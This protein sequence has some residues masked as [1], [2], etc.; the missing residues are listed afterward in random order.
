MPYIGIDLLKKMTSDEWYSR[1][2]ITGERP[3]QLHHAINFGSRSINEPFAIVPLS[4]KVHDMVTPHN[5]AYDKEMEEK[6]MLI[7]LNRAT[8]AEIRS[9]SKVYNYF[10]LR[11]RLQEKYRDFAVKSDGRK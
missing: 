6:V 9:I 1:C 3:V 5:P 7:A 4:K 2:C 11:Q 10:N 8:D